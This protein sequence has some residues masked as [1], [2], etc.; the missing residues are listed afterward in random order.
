MQ[1]H[2]V[3]LLR[4]ISHL[5]M[6]SFRDGMRDLGFTDALSYG[7]SGNLLFNAADADIAQL[8][9]RVTARLSTP[10]IVRTRAQLARIVAQDPFGSSILFLARTPGTARRQAFA[11]LDFTGPPPVIRAK[12]VYFVYPAT[13]RGKRTPLDFERALSV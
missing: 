10:A 12:S 5:G 9:R 7:M 4:A 8:E 6:Q 13:L 3:A 1:R 11:Q 2:F